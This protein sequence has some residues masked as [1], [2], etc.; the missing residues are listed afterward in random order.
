LTK[1]QPIFHKTDRFIQ[2]AGVKNFTA[3]AIQT[4]MRFA[5]GRKRLK[6]DIATMHGNSGYNQRPITIGMRQQQ[7]DIGQRCIFGKMMRQNGGIRQFLHGRKHLV[8][9]RQARIIVGNHVFR[10]PQTS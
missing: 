2:I 6:N 5:I 7:A 9:K 3:F 1:I 8:E 4:P 10:R